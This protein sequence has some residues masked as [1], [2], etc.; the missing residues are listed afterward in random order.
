MTDI[1][2][3]MTEASPIMQAAAKA[4]ERVATWSKAKQEYA[5]RIVPP[6]PPRYDR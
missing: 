6:P 2:S 5:A 3:K 4:A 1:K